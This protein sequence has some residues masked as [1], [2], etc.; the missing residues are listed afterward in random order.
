MNNLKEYQIFFHNK[1]KTIL[2]KKTKDADEMKNLR[3]ISII[4]AWLMV[5]E[6]FAEKIVSKIA[7]NYL[8]KNKFGFQTGSDCGLAKAAVMIKAKNK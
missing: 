1:I 6:K 4:P 7:E 8:T 3:T 5:C 2:I